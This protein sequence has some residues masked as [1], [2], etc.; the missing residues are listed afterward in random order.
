MVGVGGSIPL[1]PT[2]FFKDLRAACPRPVLPRVNFRVK[3]RSPLSHRW[4]WFPRSRHSA[5]VAQ[6]RL[7]HWPARWLRLAIGSSSRLRT[8]FFAVLATPFSITSISRGAG[9]GS[10]RV[11]LVV[12]DA[13]EIAGSTTAVRRSWLST[14]QEQM[15]E[16]SRNH[17]RRATFEHEADADG[18][19]MPVASQAQQSANQAAQQACWPTDTGKQF[20]GFF[21]GVILDIVGG[22]I[23]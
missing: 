1:A 21:H 15:P 16:A 8:Q 4:P 6:F 2:N 22:H 18:P 20:H 12:S 13:G 19:Y 5:A 3:I 7:P 11:G 9:P 10:P 23:G 17:L 14:N